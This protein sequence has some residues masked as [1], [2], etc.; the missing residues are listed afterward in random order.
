MVNYLEH[1]NL[2]TELK[3][4]E[5][6]NP[7]E[8]L[9]HAKKRRKEQL[10]SYSLRRRTQDPAPLTHASH[11]KRIHFQPNITLIESSARNDAD[12]V[13]KFLTSLTNN[14][15][16]D[17]QNE[18]GLSALHQAVIEDCADVVSV[19]VENGANLN[20]KD[21]DLWTPL[22]AAVACG[23]YDLVKYLIDFGAS[24]I[25]INTDGNMP[26]DLIEDNEDIEV[27][28]DESMVDAGYTEEKLE[29]IRSVI[30]NMMLED[31]R[32]SLDDERDLNI[33]G[34]HGETAC[35]IAAANGYLEVLEFLLDH[36]A[37]FDI[38]DKDDWQPIH[39]AACWGHDKVIEV[40]VNHGADLEA[41]TKDGET[42]YD[43]TEDE[44]MQEML[45]ELKESG[46]NKTPKVRRSQSNS[47]RTLSV[48]RSSIVE[49]RQTSLN[50]AKQEGIVRAQPL[51]VDI[52]TDDEPNTEGM[53]C[54][55][56]ENGSDAFQSTETAVPIENHKVDEKES[57][58]DNYISD[59]KENTIE[60]T[61]S[62]NDNILNTPK[63]SNDCVVNIN[64]VEEKVIYENKNSETLPSHTIT[65]QE[66]PPNNSTHN[67]A[68]HN[69]T[70]KTRDQNNIEIEVAECNPSHNTAAKGE[71]NQKFHD[72]SEMALKKKCCVIL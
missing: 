67:N 52:K 72:S 18:D 5:E 7:K 63:T 33:T 40:L 12:E 69:N 29:D 38:G 39:A 60:I 14:M 16:P 56:S 11:D 68:N 32:D 46:N 28:L 21:A 53:D 36:G 26:I 23:N 30:P 55:N 59:Q 54:N 27:L 15:S 17:L 42:P 9:D 25:E 64:P 71:S 45:M 1:D 50:D 10:A 20:I 22:H 34:E 66:N 58:V 3:T 70:E 8:R 41:R 65:T 6:F 2:V 43:L 31:L 57:S 35:H 44:E 49:K 51:H 13:T 48:R 47:S 61:T 4:L 19:L 37:R 24:L 62:H